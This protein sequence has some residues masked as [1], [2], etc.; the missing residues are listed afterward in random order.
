MSNLMCCRKY[1]QTDWT[2][3]FSEIESEKDKQG[4]MLEENFPQSNHPYV[5]LLMALFT[6]INPLLQL[7]MNRALTERKGTHWQS[8][9]SVRYCMIIQR[10]LQQETKMCHFLSRDSDGILLF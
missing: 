6:L 8:C 2:S 5:V 4:V 9:C 10:A 1:D 7:S 3:L